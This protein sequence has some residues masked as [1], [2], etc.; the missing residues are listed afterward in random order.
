MVSVTSSSVEYYL[1]P[2]DEIAVNGAV[3]GAST[4]SVQALLDTGESQMIPC[5]A[6]QGGLT[7]GA[8]QIL[9]QTRYHIL[10]CTFWHS[11]SILSSNSR[12][13]DGT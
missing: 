7:L 4:S 5:C 1:V 12:R 2:L 13:Q 10:V 8:L 6:G 11:R 3:V 9:V